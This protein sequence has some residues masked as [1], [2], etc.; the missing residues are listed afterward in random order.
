MDFDCEFAEM[1]RVDKVI[2]DL[3][4]R[5]IAEPDDY[6]SGMWHLL[7]KPGMRYCFRTCLD[8]FN[9]YERDAPRRGFWFSVSY[10]YIEGRH[11]TAFWSNGVP[12]LRMY[13]CSGFPFLD[14]PVGLLYALQRNHVNYN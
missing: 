8:Y 13:G 10:Q 14:F 11:I 7:T 2:E 4:N 1:E 6:P 5:K 3:G 12:H 9:K